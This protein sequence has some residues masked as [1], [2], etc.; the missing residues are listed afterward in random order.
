MINFFFGIF[1][2]TKFESVLLFY[3]FF[4]KMDLQWDLIIIH[5]KQVQVH[6]NNKILC[7]F[8]F[9]IFNNNFFIKIQEANEF[10]N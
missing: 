4:V 5:V 10:C 6:E 2:F 8:E 3:F 7:G 1:N 9:V